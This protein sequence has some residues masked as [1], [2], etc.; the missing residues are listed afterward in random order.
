MDI[1][2]CSTVRH[3]LFSLLRSLSNE[4]Q[5]SHIFFI[6]DQQKIDKN[7]YDRTCLP[8]N[9]F[10]SF[11][12]REDIKKK[13]TKTI[14]GTFVKTIAQF[15][16]KTSSFLRE[17]MRGFVFENILAL[18]N[19]ATSL[20]SAQLYLFNDRN[21]ISRVFRLAFKNYSII[22]DGLSNYSGK[23]F[24]FF[25]KIKALIL[26]NKQN[27]RYLGDDKR[28]KEIYLLKPKDAPE[29][30]KEKVKNINFITA[31]DIDKYCYNFFKVEPLQRS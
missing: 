7:N 8:E 5:V 23:K 11:I 4:G 26:F 17:K 6:C 21:K 3:L 15:N 18:K 12:K 25:E 16:I 13:L 30:I 31:K 24:N 28:C 20:E 10:I 27:M 14:T 29:F 19:S 9:I 1:Y 22:E 2:L